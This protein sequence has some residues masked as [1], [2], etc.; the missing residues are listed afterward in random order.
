[1]NENDTTCAAFRGVDRTLATLSSVETNVSALG[2]CETLLN[3]NDTTCAAF[4]GIDRTL[5]VFE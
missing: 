5:L 1:V 4:R 2:G 3:E